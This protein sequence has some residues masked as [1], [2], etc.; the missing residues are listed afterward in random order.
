MLSLDI[1][2]HVLIGMLRGCCGNSTLRYHSTY[3]CS[4]RLIRRVSRRQHLRCSQRLQWML[5]I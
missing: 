4:T 1:V 3:P 2:Y 5:W